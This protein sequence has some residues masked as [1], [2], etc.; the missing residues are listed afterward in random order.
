MAARLRRFVILSLVR[1]PVLS[2]PVADLFIVLSLLLLLP[3]YY[4]C[5]V[6]LLFSTEFWNRPCRC[7]ES[8]DPVSDVSIINAFREIP[9]LSYYKTKENCMES[10]DAIVHV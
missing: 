4:L 3:I 7:V 10:N 9:V 1:V 6:P 2:P 8:T 5:F